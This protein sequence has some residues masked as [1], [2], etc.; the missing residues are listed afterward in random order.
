MAATPLGLLD[1][2]TPCAGWD[3]RTLMGHLLGTAERAL[4]TAEGRAT[5]GV[6]HVVTG[7]ADADLAGTYA[8]LVGRI[9]RSF[10][11]LRGDDPVRAPWGACT[12][13]RAVRGFTIETVTH[14]W[15]LAVATGA[16]A[17]APAGVAE[18]CLETA[19]EIVPARLR[20]VMYDEAVQAAADASPT[21]RLANLLGHG[22]PLTDPGEDPDRI[23]SWP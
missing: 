23:S 17:D 1:G 4:G 12:A 13:A 3:V 10:G 6:P 16:P 15:D 7:I 14:G 19:G 9:V 8:G 18:R 22:R 5:R 11:G 20:G 21:E 2:P